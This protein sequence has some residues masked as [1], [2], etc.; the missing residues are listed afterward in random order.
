MAMLLLGVRPGEMK[1]LPDGTL[2]TPPAASVRIRVEWETNGPPVT[3]ALALLVALADG[4]PD[5]VAGRTMTDG[6][7]LYNGSG[8][9]SG[10][11]QASR[12]GSFISLI[13]DQAALVNSPGRERENDD[14]HVPN[15]A[16]MPKEGMPVT[17]VIT[18]PEISKNTTGHPGKS[19]DQ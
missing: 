7:W 13:G 8:F 15:A 5:N 9:D 12:E 4:N 3:R 11:F 6:P 18:C 10:G 2:T 1:T 16:L 14:I 19:A 17:V